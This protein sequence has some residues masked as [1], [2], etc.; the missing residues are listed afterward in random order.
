MKNKILLSSLFFFLFLSLNLSYAYTIY[1]NPYFDTDANSYAIYNDFNVDTYWNATCAGRAGCLI[2][3]NNGTSNNLILYKNRDLFETG[4][5]QYTNQTEVAELIDIGAYLHNTLPE[6]EEWILVFDYYFNDT[7]VSPTLNVVDGL[8]GETLYLE[9][10]NSTAGAWHNTNVT[11]PIN[12]ETYWRARTFMQ[13]AFPPGNATQ[14]YIDR[15]KLYTYDTIE[16]RYFWSS[17][18]TEELI[19][20]C[21]ENATVFPV[22]PNFTTYN[23]G[24]VGFNM[25]IGLDGY[26]CTVFK[27]GNRTIAR[28]MTDIEYS[29]SYHWLFNYKDLYF[30]HTQPP[31][32]EDVFALISAMS[33]NNMEL[34]AM[35]IDDGGEAYEDLILFYDNSPI[36][37]ANLT[38]DIGNA[39]SIFIDYNNSIKEDVATTSY[40][41]DTIA[42]A[43]WA[44]CG[45]AGSTRCGD[46][47]GFHE[48]FTTAFSCTPMVKCSS[49]TNTQYIQTAT[50]DIV[51]EQSCYT[52]GCNYTYG[53]NHGYVGTFCLDSYTWQ[54]INITG[55]VSDQDFC[56]PDERCYNISSTLT[57]LTINGLCLTPEE[58][59]TYDEDQLTF[60][61]N[62]GETMAV[63]FA[64]LLGVRDP[65]L[66]KN[67][68][69]IVIS[70]IVSFCLII[71]LALLGKDKISGEILAYSFIFCNVL[72]LLL[73]TLAGYFPIWLVTIL[74][75]LVAGIM[76]NKLGVLGGGGG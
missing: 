33:L 20:Y 26:N 60:F 15:L 43:G 31:G 69:S 63:Q 36:P 5:I 76:A 19:R 12:N 65:T 7:V 25:G 45:Q 6:N 62:P 29:G 37:Y 3:E 42:G 14:V 71:V 73:F 30:M 4:L 13:L 22:T 28:R 52:W 59:E 21:G 9:A 66:S 70:M 32:A 72:V 48:F 16:T 17:N 27:V 47:T 41:N 55:D 64:G 57:N 61:G 10:L 44:T 24:S 8:T 46:Q 51:N 68:F 39:T 23:N 56:Q 58:A 54:T 40:F 1:N 2:M 35:N 75:I 11:L 18:Q 38:T 74:I 49:I 50:C 34:T 67:I 53:C